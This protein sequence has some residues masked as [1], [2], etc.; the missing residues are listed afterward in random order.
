MIQWNHDDGVGHVEVRK[1]LGI[2]ETR[3]SH[4]TARGN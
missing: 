1:L 3:I 2:V 4:G